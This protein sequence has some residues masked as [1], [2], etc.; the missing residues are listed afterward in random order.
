MNE[1][2]CQ[3]DDWTI[4]YQLIKEMEELQTEADEKYDAELAALGSKIEEEK[5]EAAAKLSE[6][7]E[8]VTAENWE[9][10]KAEKPG[11]VP[12]QLKRKG[13]GKEMDEEKAAVLR[14][15]EADF[16]SKRKRMEADLEKKLKG[17]D[18]ISWQEGAHL[19]TKKPERSATV[20]SPYP[21][22]ASLR[23]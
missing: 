11:W 9:A 3:M 18:W 1:A 14:K 6:E 13:G 20:R 19:I 17:A 4:Y 10:W 12:D 16:E 2:Y 5:T 15:K 21:N 8:A 7:L 22:H 23:R